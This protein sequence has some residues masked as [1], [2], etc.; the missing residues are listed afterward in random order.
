MKSMPRLKNRRLAPQ[1]KGG[2]DGFDAPEALWAWV[3]YRYPYCYTG[4]GEPSFRWQ[5]RHIPN[6]EAIRLS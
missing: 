6:F 4:Q 2:I 5:Y 1:P 3:T